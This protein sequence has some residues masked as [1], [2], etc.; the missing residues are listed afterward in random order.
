MADRRRIRIAWRDALLGASWLLLACPIAIGQTTT[1]TAGRVPMSA[2][3]YAGLHAQPPDDARFRNNQR[4]IGGWFDRGS[5][6]WQLE[7]DFTVGAVARAEV[8]SGGLNP[9]GTWQTMLYAKRLMHASV[10]GIR[11]FDH[12][13]RVSA[14][15]GIG[16]G[17][18]RFTQWFEPIDGTELPPHF[19][20]QHQEDW[21]IDVAT[22]AGIDLLLGR[23]VV[24]RVAVGM[25]IPVPYLIGLKRVLVGMGYRF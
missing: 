14:F 10:M 23:H 16:G 17:I 9:D 24:A 12:G 20:T 18:L 19:R 22:A 3:I 25:D 11:R 6:K 2:G 21:G 1:D 8:Q 15:L 5:G 7:V 13:R 4:A